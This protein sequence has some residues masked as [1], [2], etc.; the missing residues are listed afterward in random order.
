LQTILGQQM[1][2]QMVLEELQLLNI[3]RDNGD[4][5]STSNHHTTSPHPA[6]V[7]K[8]VGP[9]LL[10]QPVEEAVATVKERLDFISKEGKKIENKIEAKEKHANEVAT[11]VQQLQSQLQQATAEAVRAITAQHAEA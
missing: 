2:N 10:K 5:Q 7:Y 11:K 6:V 8:M 9:I 4:G 1:E 3:T